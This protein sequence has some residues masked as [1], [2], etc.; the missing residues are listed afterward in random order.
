VVAI[1]VSSQGPSAARE[2]SFWTSETATDF[3]GGTPECVSV[4]SRSTVSL[5]PSL[6]TLL[7]AEESYFWSL[8]EDGL[9]NLYAGSGDGGRVYRVGAKGGV[10]VVLDSDELEILSLAVDRKGHVFA[11][12][13]PGGKVYRI[14]PDGESSVFFESDE[15]YIWCLAFD[16]AGNLYAGSGETGKVFIIDQDGRGEVYYETGERHVMSAVYDRGKLV[17]GTEGSGLVLSISGQEKAEVL[18][19]CDEEEVTDLA[20]DR[21]GIAYAAAVSRAKD[22]NEGADQPNPHGFGV[23]SGEQRK[24]RSSVYRIEL[25]G[26]TRRLWSTKRSQVHALWI[27]AEDSLIVGTGDEGTLY[28]LAEGKLELLQ[29]VGESQILDIHGKDGALFMCT[30][31][32]AR[33]YSAGPDFCREGTLVSKTFDA[34]GISRWGNLDW[35]VD[36]PDGTSVTFS[37]RAGNSEKPDRTWSDWSEE[38]FSAGQISETRPGRFVQWKAVLRSPR[39]SAS[40][41][42]G[43]VTLSY[44]EKNLPPRVGFVRVIP[45]GI[46]FSTGGI[47]GITDR[48]SQTLPGGVRV[49]YSLVSEGE[50]R[51]VEEAA[52]ARTFRTA[53]WDASDPNG[54]RQIFSIFYKALEE[55]N[56]K[57]LEEDF[58][59][60]IFTWNTASFPDGSYLLRV[61]ASDSPD[62]IPSGALTSESISLPFEVDNSPPAVANLRLRPDTGGVRISGSVSDEM[63]PVVALDYSLDGGAWNKLQA[64]DGLLDSEDEKFSFLLEGLTVG[65][66]SVVVRVRDRAGNIA[67]ARASVD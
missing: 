48:V 46:P 24:L 38:L 4:S 52:W 1:V 20:V 16:D 35:E 15:S 32:R 31:N 2:T 40:P 12:T 22:E 61:V 65:E 51:A 58:G 67:A 47:D 14:T 50:E 36:T 21:N 8:V 6:D 25:D 19:D 60:L 39:G 30:G 34:V 59:Q 53:V 57:L 7:S 3:R 28:C 26:T 55:Q 49:E 18:Y 45:Q 27:A 62:N 63:S 17:V 10:S 44:L 33:V 5:A 29:Q 41:S 11:G 54:D 64:S 13:S 37:V 9:G 23:P 43:K 66:H 42:L 56:W